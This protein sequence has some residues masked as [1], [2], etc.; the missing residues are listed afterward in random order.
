MLVPLC[1]LLLLLRP[2][3]VG[4][5]LGSVLREDSYLPPVLGRRHSVCFLVK[6][7]DVYQFDAS[8]PR[9]YL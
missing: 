3:C 5:G 6:W 8:C 4:E 2:A 9:F 7:L 1:C